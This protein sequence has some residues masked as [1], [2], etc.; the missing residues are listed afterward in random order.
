MPLAKPILINS[1]QQVIQCQSGLVGTVVELYLYSSSRRF[2]S[3]KC[4]FTR[5]GQRR[6]PSE[7]A[8]VGF[9]QYRKQPAD[10]RAA[11]V[12]GTLQLDGAAVVA[13]DI[14]ADS[15]GQ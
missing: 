14:V 2:D 8:S 13:S 6:L 9:F 7:R 11:Q 5:T 12:L 10:H 3:A 15:D 1:K 4:W